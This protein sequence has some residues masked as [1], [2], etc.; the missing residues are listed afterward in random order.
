M[1]TLAKEAA[2]GA[3]A[4]PATVDQFTFAETL[5]DSVLD[6]MHA[7]KALKD[8]FPAITPA[9]LTNYDGYILAFGTRFG[10]APAQVSSFF[11]QTGGLWAKGALVGKFGTTITST[12][13]QQ[14][15]QETTHLTTLP[16]LVHHGINY[17]PNGYTSPEL[18]SN[19]DTIHGGSPYGASTI[20]GPSG[21]RT[22]SDLELTIAYNQGSRFANVVNAY[23]KG[24][25][26]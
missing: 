1:R 8:E 9:D 21:D 5:P 22:P 12:G 7:N 19:N 6:L 20:A 25:Q 13:S 18:Q 17:V 4:T 15:G 10:R 23:L 3:S 11:D 14:G 16:Y 2:R 26:K 24:L